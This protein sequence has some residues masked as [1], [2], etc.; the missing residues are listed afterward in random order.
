MKPAIRIVFAIAFGVATGLSGLGERGTAFAQE[1][2]VDATRHAVRNVIEPDYRALE[3]AAARQ[4]EAFEGLCKAPGMDSREAVEVAFG[5][6]VRA[7]SRVELY[8]FGPARTENRFERL[9]FWPDPRGRGLRQVQQILAEKD[10][11]AVRVESL[12]DKSVAVQG[13]LSLDFILNGT[14][15]DTLETGEDGFRCRYGVAVSKAVRD[16]ASDLSADWSRAEGFA[17]TLT[18]PSPDN[19]IYRDG[20]ESLQELMRAAREQILIVAD[21]K[22]DRVLVDGPKSA[23]PKRA[24]FWRSRLALANIIGNIRGVRE[25]TASWKLADIVSESGTGLPEQLDF[26]LKTAE[27]V[28]TEILESGQSLGEAATRQDLHEKLRY[29]TIPLKSAARL[30]GEDIPTSLGIIA[31]F[32]SLDGD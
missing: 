26:E 19:P 21:H 28:L 11:S 13:L 7:F 15:A 14:G 29:V 31:G 17:A 6:L 25:L 12:K 27:N 8:R 24:P 10:E 32:N 1:G 18:V 30:L 4:V 9:F 5:D 22:L 3:M 23:K 2:M 16:V 20:G